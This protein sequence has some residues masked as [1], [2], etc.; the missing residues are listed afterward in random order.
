MR[1]AYIFLIATIF[2]FP[3]LDLPVAHARDDALKRGGQLNKQVIRL[4]R[5]GKYS[6]A[7]TVAKE[8][9]AIY[10][11][12][13]GPNHPNVAAGLNNLAELYAAQGEFSKAHSL[14][15]RSQGIDEKLIDH[16]M[17]FTSEDRQSIFLATRQGNLE[18]A[19][20]LAALHL[21][22]DPSVRK[23]A[24]DMW[25][26]RKGVVL[27]AKRRFQEALVYSDDPKAIST[28]QELARIRSQLSQLIFGGPGKDGPKAYQ[29]KIA[30]LEIRKRELEAKLSSL[31]QAYALKKKI[32]RADSTKVAQALP[33]ETALL[34]FVRIRT[35]N[36]KFK[37]KEKRWLPARYFTFV[38]HAGKGDRVEMIDLGD[39]REIDRNVTLLKNELEDQKDKQALS[40][41]ETS[42]KIMILC[43][44][45]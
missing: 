38:L 10:K 9:L 7:I 16:V 4:Y 12:A 39:A 29:R 32:E 37:G 15:I 11:K 2:L 17:G 3:F 22:E 14:F 33:G 25:L 36:F 20:S 41:M 27:E 5:Q 24:L 6:K 31:S 13:L 30:A 1:K 26:R 8:A 28:F 18:V 34:E 19:F 40:G 45:R 43:L 44:S 23:D 35:F 42:R 21:R